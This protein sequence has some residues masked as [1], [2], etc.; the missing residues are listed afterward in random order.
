MIH[1]DTGDVLILELGEC[2]DACR[3]VSNDD[4][5]S[6]SFVASTLL[7]CFYKRIPQLRPTRGYP[8]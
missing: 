1:I 5:L 4:L 6:H 3:N 7:Y 8:I 2:Y